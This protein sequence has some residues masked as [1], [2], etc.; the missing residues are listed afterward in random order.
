MSD[1]SDT[2]DAECGTVCDS[3][4]QLSLI[5]ML[6]ILILTPVH[7]FY[8]ILFTTAH[9]YILLAHSLG[10]KAQALRGC[11]TSRVYNVEEAHCYVI[12]SNGVT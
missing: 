6:P 3:A 11:Q 4:I 7:I 1:S 9:M 5:I 12:N 8:P 2:R 10:H